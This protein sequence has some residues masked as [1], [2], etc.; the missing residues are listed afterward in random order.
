MYGYCHNNLRGYNIGITDR[1]LRTY[2]VIVV[3]I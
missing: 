1:G 2:T 3:T